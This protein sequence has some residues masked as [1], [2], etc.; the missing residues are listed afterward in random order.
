EELCK[1][2]AVIANLQIDWYDAEGA[3]VAPFLES[4]LRM[5]VV[6]NSRRIS[7]TFLNETADKPGEAGGADKKE[8]ELAQNQAKRQ[9][10]MALATLGKRWFDAC[11]P[12]E[13]QK[14]AEVQNL[15]DAFGAPNWTT[16]L[17]KAE[18]QIGARWQQ[19]PEEINNRADA[20]AKAPLDAASESLQITDRLGHLMAAGS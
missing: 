5:K 18:D 1:K 13:L 2:L 9:G 15:L 6:I 20:A 10:R 3:L 14:F 4:S 8:E 11:K 19:M 7:H 16:A 12:G 17:A